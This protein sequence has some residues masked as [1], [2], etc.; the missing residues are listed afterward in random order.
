MSI[1]V[2]HLF[3]NAA[4]S[5][6]AI[7]EKLCAEI[8]ACGYFDHCTVQ[9][10]CEEDAIAVWAAS[11]KM[12]DDYIEKKWLV[13]DLYKGGDR[14]AFRQCWGG[15]TYAHSQYPSFALSDDLEKSVQ[16]ILEEYKNYNPEYALYMKNP[17]EFPKVVES[18]LAHK[19]QFTA[20][21]RK[22]TN[23][24]PEEWHP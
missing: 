15:L 10:S 14:A 23:V 19:Q 8:E 17:S 6:R 5:A 3:E 1:E 18:Y 12:G 24:K 9:E 22:E 20:W 16:I 13:L 7:V 11:T 2:S 4:G 21:L